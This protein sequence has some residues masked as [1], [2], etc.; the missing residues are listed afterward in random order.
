MS[1]RSS[2]VSHNLRLGCHY[3]PDP[4]QLMCQPDATTRQ[5]YTMWTYLAIELVV[6]ITGLFAAASPPSQAAWPVSRTPTTDIS[7]SGKDGRPI[8]GV[9]VSA[10]R[11]SDGTL[12]VAD[13]AENAVVLVTPNAAAPVRI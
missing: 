10:A 2:Y 11:H 6:V 4:R 9:P 7:G 8:I 5:R 3:A 13:A 1:R 12:A